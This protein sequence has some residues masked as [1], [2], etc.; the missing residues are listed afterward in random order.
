MGTKKMVVSIVLML[1]LF[2][3]IPIGLVW[4]YDHSGFSEPELAGAAL[5]LIGV[6]T[7][8]FLLN[9]AIRSL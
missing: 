9:R 5:V 2:P 8:I 4:L 1:T 7:L 6:P 3:G